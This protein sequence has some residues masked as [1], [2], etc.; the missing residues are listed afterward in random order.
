MTKAFFLVVSKS[1]EIQ[2]LTIRPNLVKLFGP[3]FAE[4]LGQAE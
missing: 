2:D 3:F 4:K 1:P